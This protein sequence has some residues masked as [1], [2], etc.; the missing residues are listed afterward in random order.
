[1][2]L[3][4]FLPSPNSLR[5]TAV[6]HELGIALE[7]VPMDLAKGDHLQPAFLKLNPNHKIPVLED[8]EFVLWES[9]AIMLYLSWSAGGR[10]IPEDVKQRAQMHQWMSWNTAHL[11]PAC[12]VFLFENM[13]KGLLNL[14]A[15]NPKQLARADEE[16]ARF[17]AVLDGHLAGRAYL[18]GNGRTLADHHVF[19]SLVHAGGCGLPVAKFPEIR[20]WSE[21]MRASASWQHALAALGR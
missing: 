2:K 7:L 4:T 17:G 8:G 16:F 11:G 14:G 18:V 12:G 19:A 6:A 15:P 20:R 21:A 13:V 3:H 5:V 1:M 10:L 9:T